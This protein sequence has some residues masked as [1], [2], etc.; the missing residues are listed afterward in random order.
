MSI[1]DGCLVHGPSGK[2][3]EAD[4]HEPGSCQ[5]IACLRARAAAGLEIWHPLDKR[6]ESQPRAVDMEALRRLIAGE[7]AR[8]A[9]VLEAVVDRREHR[10]LPK[11]SAVRP[12]DQQA[13]RNK[14]RQ[15]F[16]GA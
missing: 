11:R 6:T 2:P 1:R 4:N 5:R 13:K 16:Y 3:T 10:R 12:V 8:A 9:C 14:L 15:M 7:T